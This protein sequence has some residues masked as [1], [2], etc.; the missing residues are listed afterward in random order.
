MGKQKQSDKRPLWQRL[1][2]W[3]GIGF[4]GLLVLSLVLQALG[5]IPDAEE[6]AA[7]E[8]AEA[9]AIASLPTEVPSITPTH[10]ET[11]TAT[12]TPIPSETPIPSAT[13]TITN[14]PMP[15][16]T[17]GPESVA[18]TAFINVFG[19]NR[20]IQTLIVNERVVTIRFPLTDLSVRS[21]RFEAETRLVD[22]TCALREA[23]FTGRTYQITGTI[24]LVDDF[25]NTF[26]GEGVEAIIPAEVVQ[27]INCEN[28]ALVDL[29]AIAERFDLHP[30]LQ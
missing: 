23:G 14:T 8:T 30:A 9:V 18:E 29:A 3:G 27:Q 1:L 22:L 11:A 13:A 19:R 16:P 10:T 2:I 17:L 12:I 20:E 28:M 7:T 26:P 4:V 6:R 15:T 24:M 25:G 21:A 5:V